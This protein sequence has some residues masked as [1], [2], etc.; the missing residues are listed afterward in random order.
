MAIKMSSVFSPSK[1]LR[2]KDSVIFKWKYDTQ[3]ARFPVHRKDR[4]ATLKR[5]YGP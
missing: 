5:S 2:E 4:H 3:E 1:V